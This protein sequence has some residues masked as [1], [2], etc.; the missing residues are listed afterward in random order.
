[1]AVIHIS[2][3]HPDCIDGK[4]TKA[5]K[6]LISSQNI[7]ENIV[8]SLNRTIFRINKLKVQKELHGFTLYIFG[9]PFG[10]LLI[11]W[12]YIAY[13]RITK[14]IE[15]EKIRPDLIHA[16]KLTYEG[17][18]AFFLSRKFK[19]PFILTVRGDSDL[20]LLFYKKL[21]RKFYARIVNYAKKV[22]FL[23]PW[24]IKPIR[25]YIGI[26]SSSGK[27]VLIPNIVSISEH[28]EEESNTIKKF[29]TVFNFKVYK[30]K[31]IIRVIN[32]FES[33]LSQYPDYGLDIVGGGPN[34]N[35]IIS[36]IQKTSHP[37]HFSFLG[38]I[39]NSSLLKIY[40]RYQGFILPSFPETFGLV[41]IEALSAG[42]PVIYSKNAGIDGFF[43]D[44]NIGIAVDHQ[45]VEEIASALEKIIQ[46]GDIYKRN[47]KKLISDDYF[48]KFS[49][50]TVG[51]RYSEII[52]QYIL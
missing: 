51:E 25:E 17:I 10:I 6:N 43:D 13:R 14:I 37:D 9:L 40:A 42:I 27:F 44:L 18:I 49:K 21:Y 39:E 20:K 47:I 45:S 29:I 31:N 32:A 35:K 12:M 24:V 11:L 34:K 38:E 52:K 1:M 50:K 26:E 8:F 4:K 3:D 23:A 19:V 46:Q 22:I 28:F 41:F 2:F 48:Q 5:V 30:R 36:Y 16:H 33:I 15:K 7:S